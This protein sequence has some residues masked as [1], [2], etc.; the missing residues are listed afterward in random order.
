MRPGNCLETEPN[1]QLRFINSTGTPRSVCRQRSRLTGS[2]PAEGQQHNPYCGHSR[3]S[4]RAP[5]RSELNVRLKFHNKQ[6]TPG[7]I[8]LSL[9]KRSLP[10]HNIRITKQP[11]LPNLQLAGDPAG[12]SGNIQGPEDQDLQYLCLQAADTPSQNLSQ[13]FAQSNDFIHTARINGG[14]VLVHW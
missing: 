13:F 5:G 7:E 8:F 4:S 3:Y 6:S 12:A 2:G 9:L 10:F 11:L 1:S 14:N